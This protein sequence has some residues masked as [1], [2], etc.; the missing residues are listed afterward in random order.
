MQRGIVAIGDLNLDLLFSGLQALPA[1]GRE[2]LAERCTWKPGGSCANTAMILKGIG[3]P[4]WLYGRIGDDRV[5][6]EIVR[7]LAE[8]EF[9]TSTISRVSGIPTGITVALNS[10]E[11]RAYVTAPGA[12][13][14]LV[15][16]DLKP[17]YIRAGAHLH[18]AS[19]F[20]QLALQ[21]QVGPLL[22]Q[23]KRAGMSTS[24]DPG[25]DPTGKWDLTVLEPF[26]SS[27][28]WFLP[29]AQ[30]LSAITGVGSPEG[31]LRRFSHRVKG[32]V[33]KNGPLGALV[34]FEGQFHVCEVAQTRVVDPSCAGD[35]FNAGF[36]A[37]VCGGLSVEQAV[38]YGNALGAAAVSTVGLPSVEAVRTIVST[39]E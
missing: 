13:S 15:L 14:S 1:P 22:V 20:L 7:R 34:R 28:D 33:V 19:F 18:L 29:N 2:V 25:H 26:W 12:V 17:G 8:M 31:A 6:D 38:Q 27:L 5:G 30:E 23:A 32:V 3:W 24:L 35:S 36:L 39:K 4:V 9:D 37:G 21:A 11:D 10:T 16:D